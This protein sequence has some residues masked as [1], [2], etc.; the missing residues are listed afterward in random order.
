MTL[1]IRSLTPSPNTVDLEAR[2]VEAIVSTGA[3]TPRPGFV[4]RLDLTGADL[5]GLVGAPLLD[6]HQTR[7]TRDQLGV[8]E[9]AEL[10]A[11]GLWIRAKFRSNP[12]ALSVLSDIADGTLRGLSIGYTVAEWKESRSGNRLVRT[13]TRWKPI[14]VSIVP[15]PADPGA[16]FRAGNQ[17]MPEEIQTAPEAQNPPPGEVITR[18]QVNAQIRT[19]AQTAGLTRAWADQQIDAEVTPDQARQA[20]FDEMQRRSAETTTRTARAVIVTDHTDPAQIATRAGEALYAR[21]HP[22]HQISEPARAY[23]AMTTI[24]LARD[25]LRRSGVAMTGMS[26]DTVITRA[27]HTTSDFSLILGDAVGRE[28]RR[29]Y[30]AAPSGV[31]QVA[32]QTTARDFR[33]KRGLMFGDGPDLEKVKE[34]GEFSHG[35]IEESGES[36]SVE[37]F[38]RIFAIS[39]QALVNDDL[40]AFMQVPARLGNAARR[41]EAD[42]LVKK[43]LD[44]PAMSDEIAV[45]HSDRGNIDPLTAPG[46]TSLSTAR[47]AMRHRKGLAGELINAT[48]RFVLV[49][50][51][52]ETMAEQ[53]LAEIAATKTGDHNPFDNLTLV[54]DP[55]LPGNLWFVVADPALIDGLEY[56]YL[57]GAPGPQI[58]TK[59]G[60]EVD[61]VQMKIRLD[62]GCGW[63]DWRSWQRIGPNEPPAEPES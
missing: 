23:A 25:C 44:N 17:N 47:T 30:Q 39:R 21:S 36:Y 15:V 56:A 58:E 27:L 14:E 46:L 53:A 4:E 16:H 45:F 34:G 5:S 38:G 10:R 13:A 8:I 20:A 37:T 19:I 52:L 7:S 29:S 26:A 50:A 43:L 6:A 61:G 31:M 11:E 57:E 22:E 2:T 59:Q 9:A 41:F 60:F 12:A 33:A 49:P 62:F 32:R 55:R 42:A 40:G 24:D 18:A 54:V 35:T 51:E 63:M 48:P 1:H 28:L 3:D